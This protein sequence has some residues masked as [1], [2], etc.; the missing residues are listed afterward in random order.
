M[1]NTLTKRRWKDDV[2]LLEG[3]RCGPEPISPRLFGALAGRRLD[4]TRAGH[5]NSC[6]LRPPIL[7]GGSGE[8]HERLVLP[9]WLTRPNPSVDLEYKGILI[10]DVHGLLDTAGSDVVRRKREQDLVAGVH[11]LVHG[12]RPGITLMCLIPA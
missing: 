11:L 8:D 1:V 6:M 12:N 5:N 7:A 10:P 2:V 9:A 3:Y 4:S